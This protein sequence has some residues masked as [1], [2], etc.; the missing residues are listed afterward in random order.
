M[1]CYQSA[2]SVVAYLLCCPN[3]GAAGFSV[4]KESPSLFNRTIGRDR[5]HSLALIRLDSTSLIGAE[6]Q[7]T[8]SMESPGVSGTIPTATAER[9]NSQNS[10]SVKVY[11]S[12]PASLDKQNP[13]WLASGDSDHDQRDLELEVVLNR[14]KLTNSPRLGTGG[15]IKTGLA[16][17]G[18]KGKF[19]CEVTPYISRPEYPSPKEVTD[20]ENLPEVQKVPE[21]RPFFDEAK[22]WAIASRNPPT[23]SFGPWWSRGFLTSEE[24][25]K[26]DGDMPGF[27]IGGSSKPSVNIDHVYECQLL[28]M[29]FLEMIQERKTNC[30]R[31]EAVF[32][33]PHPE[34]GT[35]LNALFN[36]L[37]KYATPEFVGMD[38][39]INAAKALIWRL[40]I[41]NNDAPIQFKR[42]GGA[43][44]DDNKGNLGMFAIA[45]QAQNDPRFRA[46]FEMTNGRIYRAFADI[47][48]QWAAMYK[49]WM[50][51]RIPRQNLGLQRAARRVISAIPTN[52]ADPAA[53]GHQD[54]VPRWSSYMASLLHDFPLAAMTL[55]AVQNWPLL[56]VAT[57][58]AANVSVPTVTSGLLAAAA[59]TMGIFPGSTAMST[60]SITAITKS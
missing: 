56:A 58:A 14:R 20:N 45:L 59:T 34:L 1:R 17:M 22:Y 13:L 53:A 50:T 10:S 18:R 26:P 32:D 60:P 4:L 55:P 7:I 36:N 35:K 5:L 11:H 27:A 2:V 24:V 42:G 57:A 23:S 33:V 47:D 49:A 37:P 48:P 6:S 21:M 52:T 28:D 51:A 38:S 46:L 15:N 25:G 8:S 40:N 43:A 54:K 39:Q 44:A 29:F 3:V 12:D 30:A 16:H 19:L 31:I 41:D 9:A